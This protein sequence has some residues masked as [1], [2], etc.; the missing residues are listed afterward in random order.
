MAKNLFRTLFVVFIAYI[1][2]IG[3]QNLDK[4][5]SFVGCFACIPL[6][7]MYPPILHLKSCCKIHSGLLEKEQNNRFWLSLANY[8]LLVIGAISFVYTTYE[9]LFT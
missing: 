4:F 9:I 2:Y 8:V 6:V 1:A 5:V 3:G 7:Y